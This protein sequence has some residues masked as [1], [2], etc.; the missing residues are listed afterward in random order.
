MAKKGL[1]SFLAGATFGGLLTL[2]SANRKGSEVRKAIMSEW[3]KGESGLNVLGKE[4]KDLAFEVKDTITEFYNSDQV[5]KALKDLGGK[6][7]ASFDEHYSQTM[8]TLS[9][10]KNITTK[11]I[12]EAQKGFEKKLEEAF[13]HEDDE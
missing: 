9:D 12:K 7:K 11:K 3:K 13:S 10:V 5:Q 2:L 8:E 4:A 1:F 6:A